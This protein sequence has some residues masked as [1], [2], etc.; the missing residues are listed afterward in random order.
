MESEKNNFV[1][2]LKTI[3][4]DKDNGNCYHDETNSANEFDLSDSV[5]IRKVHEGIISKTWKKFFDNFLG[6]FIINDRIIE[7]ISK[8]VEKDNSRS[9]EE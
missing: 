3:Y 7:K 1:H 2:R 8:I 4:I 5:C 6:D 9:K